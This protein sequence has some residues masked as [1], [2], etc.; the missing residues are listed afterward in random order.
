M[1]GSGGRAYAVI[2]DS[3]G[4]QEETTSLG[5]PCLTL[6]Q[7]TERPSRSVRAPIVWCLSP[8]I[9]LASFE[10]MVQILRSSEARKDGTGMPARGSSARCEADSR[11]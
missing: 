6:R 7:N 4:L 9:S 11:R 2:T 1:L 3:G 10:A 5:V 8:R